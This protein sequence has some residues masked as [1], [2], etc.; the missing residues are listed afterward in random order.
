MP[1]PFSNDLRL[2][3]GAT[4]LN[5]LEYGD[6][7]LNYAT[8]EPVLRPLTLPFTCAKTLR[9]MGPNPLPNGARELRTSSLSLF[10]F[11]FRYHPT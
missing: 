1:Q 3:Y 6:T 2:N 7:P 10:S 8:T 5:Y 11:E 9:R 4:T